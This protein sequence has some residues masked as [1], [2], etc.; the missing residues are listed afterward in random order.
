MIGPKPL[1][2]RGRR[3]VRPHVFSIRRPVPVCF[4]GCASH[5]KFL[6]AMLPSPQADFRA[7]LS[8]PAMSHVCSVKVSGGKA[9]GFIP[10]AERQLL[11]QVEEIPALS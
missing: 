1:L 3:E 5:A 9:L 8:A 7:L 2:V 11:P 10:A 6:E 4:V